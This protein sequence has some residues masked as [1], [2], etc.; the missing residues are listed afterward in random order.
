MKMAEHL[1]NI[2]IAIVYIVLPIF[3]TIQL[4]KLKNALSKN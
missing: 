1:M 2:M 3:N 4:I